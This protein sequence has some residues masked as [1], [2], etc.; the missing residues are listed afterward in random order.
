MLFKTWNYLK[1]SSR[2]KWLKEAALNCCSHFLVSSLSKGN[3]MTLG[4]F[5]FVCNLCVGD[6]FFLFFLFYYYYNFTILTL[7]IIIY[8]WHCSSVLENL[9]VLPAQHCDWLTFF[10]P[11][12]PRFSGRVLKGVMNMGSYNYLGFARNRGICADASS[13]ELLQYGGGVC[14]TRQEMGEYKLWSGVCQNM[15][16]SFLLQRKV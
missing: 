8:R 10:S 15:P 16:V 2:V 11:S 6:F 13:S 3:L 5:K 1:G 14:S 4:S 7:Q 9:R 12:P